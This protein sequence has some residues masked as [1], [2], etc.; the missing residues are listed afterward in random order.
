MAGKCSQESCFPHETGCHIEGNEYAVD[1]KFYNSKENKENLESQEEEAHILS[2]P[3]T[4][5]SLG[6][7]D[8]NFLTVSSNPIIIGVTG[9][10]SAGK[11][12]FLSTL[13]CLLR[14][15]ENIGEY[16]F[17]GSLT[18]IGWE[19]IA[20]Y[21]SWR[22]N[23]AIQYPPHTSRNAGRTPGL[24]HLSLR[25][26][27]G[28]RK[29]L[30][31]TDAPGEWFDS[32][33]YN[34]NDVNAE[35]ARWIHQNSDAFFLFADS[36]MLSGSKRGIA[37]NQI[38]LV[39]DRLKENLKDKPFGL[40]WSKSDETISADIKNQISTYIKNSPIENYKEFETSVRE[41]E[42]GIFHQNILKSIEWVLDTI[43]NQKNNGLKVSIQKADDLFLSKR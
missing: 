11:T 29:D 28:I 20:W 40:I 37:R 26:Q 30:I 15:G 32:W 8:L 24:L 41:G 17:A 12:T 10:A 35:G 7:T 36:E 19:N 18:L 33:I 9:V 14:N 2:L 3:W 1:C 23:N 42:K 13:Y 6:L 21:L 16:R 4:G 34:K 38:K 39:G 22:D 43:Q 27:D 25:N 5:N 31:F